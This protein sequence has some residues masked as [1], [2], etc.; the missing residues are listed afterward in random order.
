[1]D[2]ALVNL[3]PCKLTS[4][5]REKW[6]MAR[7]TTGTVKRSG[8]ESLN[9]SEDKSVTDWRKLTA[10]ALAG[11]ICLFGLTANVAAKPRND[12]PGDNPKL[13][14]KL[15]DRANLGGSGNSRAIVVLKPGCD[16]TLDYLK[17]G[18]KRG[19]RLGLINADVVELSNAQLRKLA[20]S[21]CVESMHHDRSSGGEMNRAAIVEGARAVQ[22]QYG[23]D[24]A[25][26]GVAV[27]DTGVTSWHDDLTYLGSN[28]LVKVVNGQRVMNFVDFV[29]CHLLSYH[30]NGHRSHVAGII[31]GNGL[32]TLGARAGMAPGA[33]LVSLKV[34]DDHAA[35]YISNVIA[36]LDWVVAN[37][38]T[39]NIRVVNLSVCAAVTQ[40]E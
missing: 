2:R 39:Y 7:N 32:D 28:S 10:G 15:N 30:D 9:F 8:V 38:T 13:D 11:A 18:G 17:V 1:M 5:A 40:S 31:A 6:G 35:G 4:G 16:A 12:R 25:G 37:R 26:I 33:N 23:Y 34:L 19:R 24:G 20:G 21:A 22:A 36:A 3:E 14:R 27:I 29:N